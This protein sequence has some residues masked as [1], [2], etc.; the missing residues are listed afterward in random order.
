[1][2]VFFESIKSVYFI[3]I[4]GI[5][6]SA[7]A[8]YSLCEGKK[9]FGSDSVF[10]DSVSEL[11]NLG[12][13]V[14][15]PK[16]D[17]SSVKPDVIVYSSAV[18]VKTEEILIA[19]S[20]NI[21]VMKRS[22]YLGM[23]MERFKKSVSVCGCHGK[24]TVSAML[25]H[26]F[27]QSHY[28][29]TVFIG[30]N[31]TVYNNFFYGEKD[32]VIAE[33]CE[34]KKNFLDMPSD[35]AVCVNIDYD[36]PDT[37]RNLEDTV[38]CFETF[39]KGKRTVVNADDI[40]SR[41]LLKN[42]TVSFG[43]NNG[44][45]RAKDVIP[46]VNGND[47]SVTYKGVKIMEVSLK[48][49][50]LFNIYNALCAI[51]SALLYNIDY[52]DISEA[53]SDFHGVKRRMEFLGDISGKKTYGDYAHHPKE[54]KETLNSFCDGKTIVVFQPHTYSRT[55]KLMCEFVQSLVFP[56]KVIIYKTYPARELYNEKG[57]GYTLYKKLKRIRR[58]VYYAENE[59]RLKCLL[60][61]K[62]KHFNKVIFLGAGD[63]YDIAK[64]I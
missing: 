19:K 45:V 9:V 42:A 51:A 38:S 29:P 50:G 53:L 20:L 18:S 17:V 21:P 47:F 4:G 52:L 48:L 55:E 22:E 13:T 26:I 46:T 1:M 27:M 24:T 40:N 11:K 61:K 62:G 15:I 34:Y 32:I 57:D 43:I 23:I 36:H 14:Y 25:T 10:F 37:F 7:L 63:I 54:I 64:K 60:D 3:G 59:Q 6:M 33:A 30:G 28:I 56:K 12:A 58:G 8:K 39:C 44:D 35:T 41:S 49:K 16:G 5:S 2:K 31:D